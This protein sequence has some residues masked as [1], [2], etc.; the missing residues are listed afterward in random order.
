MSTHYI[1]QVINNLNQIL[2]Y[3]NIIDLHIYYV[4]ISDLF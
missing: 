4:L 1:S 3:F 2:L